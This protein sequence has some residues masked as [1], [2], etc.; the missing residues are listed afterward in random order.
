MSYVPNCLKH[1]TDFAFLLSSS[2]GKDSGAQALETVD[3]GVSS[4]L[5]NS[6][7][8]SWIL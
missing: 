7:N 6:A 8:D 5:I 3:W 4:P 2:L 1:G